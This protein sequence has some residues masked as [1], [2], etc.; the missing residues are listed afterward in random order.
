MTFLEKT[1]YNFIDSFIKK[2]CS[3]SVLLTCTYINLLPGTYYCCTKLRALYRSVVFKHNNISRQ[4][5]SQHLRC[6]HCSPSQPD[7]SLLKKQ[8]H[9]ANYCIK[10]LERSYPQRCGFCIRY[11]IYCNSKSQCDYIRMK[12]FS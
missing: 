2:N 8:L 3:C 5:S 12:L 9:V 10:R 4:L 11:Y 1:P 6:R 7:N